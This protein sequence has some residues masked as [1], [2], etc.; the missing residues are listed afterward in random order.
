MPWSG[1]WPD[2]S[3]HKMSLPGIKTNGDGLLG[4]G[5]A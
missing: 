4:P 5:P 1:I 3:E 2:L